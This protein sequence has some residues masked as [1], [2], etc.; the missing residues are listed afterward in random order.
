[1]LTPFFPHPNSYR[2]SYLLDQAKAIK[3]Q[4]NA[5]LKVIILSTFYS[6]LNSNY[7]IEGID[8]LCFKIIDFPSFIFPGFFN[9]INTIR[10]K[11]FLQKNNI[12][13]SSETYVHGHINYP[14]NFLL[15]FLKKSF[16]AKTILQHHALDILQYE[17]GTKIPFLKAIQNYI[18]NN[19][20]ASS[21]PFIDAHIVV[22]SKVKEKLLKIDSSLN[23]K[24]IV[25]FNGVDTT[26]FFE[27]KIKG[28]ST[29]F[30]IGCV[31]NFWKLKDHMT[32]LRAVKILS[33][34]GLKNVKI[35]FVGEGP[36]LNAC[37]KFAFKHH[38]DCDFTIQK[39]HTE[40][41]NF[42][43]D[44]DLF[45]LPSYYEAF[46]CVYLESLACGTPFVAVKGQGI[47]D[48]IDEKFKHIQLI[49]KKNDKQL[50]KII[51][52]FYTDKTKIPFNANFEI[53]HIISKML[54]KIELL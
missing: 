3:R 34:K 15:T 17:T 45:V 36:T 28:P 22:S 47:E 38:I 54:Y 8:C 49:D 29:Y 21:H 13:I 41:I 42:Y 1:M 44:I 9:K 51:E 2:G 48:T 43:N 18:I 19:H 32:L 24:T 4:T 33:D 35:Q 23:G 27:K 7:T 20:F 30:K 39:K 31:A 40:L 25:C 10:F 37:K 11:R 5:R 46:G 12:V 52:H 6:S 26:K 53:N 50:S 16:N 14:S